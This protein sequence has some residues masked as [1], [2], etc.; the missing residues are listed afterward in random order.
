LLPFGN[1]QIPLPNHALFG[2]RGTAR[3]RL[4]CPGKGMNHAADGQHM[5]AARHLG[6]E[7]PTFRKKCRA[8]FGRKA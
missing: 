3:L 2:S 5:I 4:G 1:K 8:Y 6:Y 7:E